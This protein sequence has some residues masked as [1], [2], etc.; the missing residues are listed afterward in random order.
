VVVELRKRGAIGNAVGAVIG[1]L[2]G[3][4]LGELWLLFRSWWKDD[5]FPP[6]TAATRRLNPFSTFESVN[7]P[8]TDPKVAWWKF[9]T[10]HYE[11]SY[12]WALLD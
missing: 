8:V 7:A 12:D 10:S 9:D 5:E 4:I 1:A 2:V 11:L 3:W 6:I